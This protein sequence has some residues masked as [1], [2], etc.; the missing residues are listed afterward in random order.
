MENC[1]FLAHKDTIVVLDDT[2]FT[3]GWKKKYTR[4]PTRTWIEHIQENKIIELG[5]KDY[6]S[7]KGM[8][9]GKYIF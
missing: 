2:N 3:K 1:Y 7:G 4:G 8:S 6:C 9:W 5:R